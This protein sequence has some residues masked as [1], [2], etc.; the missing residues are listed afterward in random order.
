MLNHVAFNAEEPV[1][2]V[3]LVEVPLVAPLVDMVGA[4]V[5]CGRVVSSAKP[6]SISPIDKSPYIKTL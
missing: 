5:F 2:V 3:D 6:A 1:L 4:N